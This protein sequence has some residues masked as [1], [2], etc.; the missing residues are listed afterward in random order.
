MRSA[1]RSKSRLKLSCDWIAPPCEAIIAPCAR[2]G[3]E[4]P[5]RTAAAMAIIIGTCICFWMPIWRA[6][7]RCVTCAISCAITEAT[8]DSLSE[9]LISPVLTPMKPP[10]SA[11]ALI[12]VSR[13]A[14]NSKSWRAPGAAEVRRA[15]RPFRYSAT[16]GSSRYDGSRRRISRMTD[17]PMRRS[18]CSDSSADPESPRSGNGAGD[19]CPNARGTCGRKAP[20]EAASSQARKRIRL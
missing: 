16:S 15:P 19:S 20:R 4:R 11:K 18:V 6:I 10:G 17:S 13:T 1:S 8:S 12:E 14:K 2:S 5:S 3:R 7:W 9:T